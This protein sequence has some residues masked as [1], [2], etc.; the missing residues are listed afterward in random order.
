MLKKKLL[1]I[2]TTLV[3][4]LSSVFAI[5]GV[6]AQ[7]NLEK[8][9]AIQEKKADAEAGIHK[10]EQKLKRLQ[11]KQESLEA[12]ISSIANAINDSAEKIVA[13][14]KEIK[15]TQEAIKEL[16]KEIAILKER[17][18]KRNALLKER[19]VSFQESGGDVS[20]LEVLLGSSSFSDFVGRM[21]AVSTIVEA[22][23][24]L[25]KQ[26][27][28]D[29]KELEEKQASIEKKLSE[30]KNMLAEMVEMKAKLTKQKK[31]QDKL[32]HRLED[33][34]E[35]TH[36]MKMSFEEEVDTLEAQ[37]AAVE[38][39]IQLEQ[40]R[41]EAERKR[42]AAQPRT[43]NTTNNTTHNTTN[44]T[45]NSGGG[46]SSNVSKAPAV[47]S[48]SF[49]RPSAGRVTSKM[50]A[51]WNKMHAGIDIAQGGTVPVVAAA[52]GVVMR[53]YTSSTYGNCVMIS[54]SINGQLYTT[55]YAHLRSKNVSQGQTV[56]KGQQ[57][58]IM[59]NT[60]R[61]F[62]QHLHFE[63]HKGPWNVSKTNAVNPLDYV[64]Y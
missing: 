14:K 32:M 1:V 55:V 5:P 2:N 37:E 8:K 25:L 17:I 13:K 50:G 10:A 62:G 16:E 27:E 45:T 44:N 51:R 53:S 49:T 57:I 54:H 28:L 42:A 22:D 29:K 43:N 58:G 26:H 11:N 59:G 52:G 31:Q 61:S 63:I 24:E 21:S 23:Q 38:K 30:L 35:H 41:Q 12:K 9:Q 33:K 48:G 4:G 60:G 20:Y 36:N 19:A 39:A 40:K 7:T 47:S 46:N 3:L 34:E 64:S 56:S 15:E 6:N 18:K